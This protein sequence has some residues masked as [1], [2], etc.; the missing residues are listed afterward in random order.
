MKAA[1]TDY[2]E[3]SSADSNGERG[4]PTI[5]A[6]LSRIRAI[7]GVI[8]GELKDVPLYY[9]IGNLAST[10]QIQP[11]TSAMIR[12]ALVNAGYRYSY[13][14]H[15]PGAIKTD[16]PPSVVWD[17]MRQGKAKPL[18]GSKHKKARPTAEKI[19]AILCLLK[20]TSHK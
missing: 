9:V 17:I 19:W 10:L 16:A 7:L 1:T 15:E 3:E 20:W 2:V 14:H 18:S 4:D 13:F 8:S 12:S 5:P 11:P 6:T